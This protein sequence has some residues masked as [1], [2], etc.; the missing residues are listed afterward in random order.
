MS[1]A[2]PVPPAGIT[3]APPPA[4]PSH[5]RQLP[6]TIAQEEYEAIAATHGDNPPTRYQLVGL[7][8]SG[9]GIRSATFGLG[10][11]ESAEEARPAEA[12]PL[13][14][15]RLRRRLHRRL[16][17]RQ[18]PARRRARRERLAADR[19]RRA[20]WCR[21]EW[22]RSIEHLRRYSN[23]L[24]PEVG[25]FSADTWSM[26]TVW[27]RNA[28]LVQWTVIVAVACVLLLPRLLPWL[29]AAWPDVRRLRWLGGR[30]CSCS[31]SSASPAT[32]SG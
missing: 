1:N 15:D 12:D 2:A 17:Q 29:F 13:P 18:L 16:V 19:D 21:R 23:Y 32:S 3:G 20:D 9:G 5:M 27:L 28:L 22:G 11:L 26:F 10:V 4:A 24:S 14:V 6:A 25:F 8:L 31:A 30:R 7:A